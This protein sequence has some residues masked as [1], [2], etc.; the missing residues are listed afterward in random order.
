MSYT[1]DPRAA[2]PNTQPDAPRAV[3]AGVAGGSRGVRLDVP[4]GNTS[5]GNLGLLTQF[6]SKLLEPLIKKEQEQAFIDGMSRAASGEAA[7]EIEAKRPAWAS[8]FGDSAATQGARLF[9]KITDAAALQ[10]E[11]AESLTTDRA[12]PP[13]EY[14]KVL[15]KRL[16]S[17]K[18]GDPTRDSVYMQAALQFL[19]DAMRMQAKAHMAWQQDQ[20]NAS[21]I[22]MTDHVIAAA[23]STVDAMS[24]DPRVKDEA[25]YSNTV[26]AVTSLLSPMPGI[27]F[28]KQVRRFVDG[29]QAGMLRGEFGVMQM[30][31]D[32]GLLQAM[33]PAAAEALMATERTES[34]RALPGKIAE[35]IPGVVEVWSAALVNSDMTPDQVRAVARTV[36]A[37]V[38]EATGIRAAQFVTDA[39][40]ERKIVQDIRDDKQRAE[41][42]KR[43]QEAEARAIQRENQREARAQ[44]AKLAEQAYTRSL[45]EGLS[46]TTRGTGTFGTTA[47]DINQRIPGFAVAAENMIMEKFAAGPP[48]VAGKRPT[49][50]E[51]AAYRANLL[52]DYTGDVGPIATGIQQRLLSSL[53]SKEVTAENYVDLLTIAALQGSGAAGRMFNGQMNQLAVAVAEELKL[54]PS[55]VDP[56]T[57]VE[58]AR[59]KVRLSDF[60]NAPGANVAAAAVKEWRAALPGKT[61][62]EYGDVSFAVAAAMK[63]VG[64]LG[65]KEGKHLQLV[66]AAAR[67]GVNDIGGVSFVQDPELP[68]FLG[69]MQEKDAAPALKQELDKVLKVWNIGPQDLKIT[70]TSV[71]ATEGPILT[72]IGPGKDSAGRRMIH[73]L[74]LKSLKEARN[75]RVSDTIPKNEGMLGNFTSP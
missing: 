65:S 17:R 38:V 1:I 58:T 56:K 57:I 25:A 29:V 63:E 43:M 67:L 73:Q 11:V 49:F 50:Q 66:G 37:N 45:L 10:R 70:Y 75:N 8:A 61:A 69:D 16:T 13:D 32:N 7:A 28:D 21:A 54:N 14:S 72:V 23:H 6:G 31:K 36:N 5:V 12:M 2:V 48:V 9:E 40:V 51:T 26:A 41:A 62:G 20:A 60:G 59:A 64:H 4:E 24:K 19:P 27:D 71:S 33:P 44:A 39:E 74:S 55:G 47:I 52:K 34:H 15:Y 18:S 30:L 53:R 68:P 42:E 35:R 3:G 22:Q 46:V